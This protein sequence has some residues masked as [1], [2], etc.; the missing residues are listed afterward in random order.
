MV[1]FYFGFEVNGGT[2]ACVEFFDFCVFLLVSV[3]RVL[4]VRAWLSQLVLYSV[5]EKAQDVD[6]MGVCSSFCGS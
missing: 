2:Q 4:S 3:A 5:V 1:A 6:R